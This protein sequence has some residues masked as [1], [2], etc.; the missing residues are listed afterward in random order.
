MNR[1]TKLVE[2]IKSAKPLPGRQVYLPGEKGDTL[3]TKCE[4]T[5]EVEIADA[6][7]NELIAFIEN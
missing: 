6:I 7:W 3:A 1:A 5:G 2:Q 4:E